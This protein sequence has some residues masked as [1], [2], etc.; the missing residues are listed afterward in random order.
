MQTK[1]FVNKP[2]PTTQISQPKSRKAEA[3]VKRC[4]AIWDKIAKARDFQDEKQ[5]ESL[6]RDC[7]KICGKFE[8][9]DSMRIST[10]IALASLLSGQGRIQESLPFLKNALAQ[11]KRHHRENHNFFSDTLL[12]ASNCFRNAGHYRQAEKVASTALE[13][14]TTNKKLKASVTDIHESL[15]L[16]RYT[17]GCELMGAHKYKQA[18]EVFESALKNVKPANFQRLWRE[19]MTRCC[20]A[21]SAAK[22]GNQAYAIEQFQT[23]LTLLSRQS[24]L[25]AQD[26]HFLLLSIEDLIHSAKTKTSSLKKLI[27]SN[28]KLLEK[29]RAKAKVVAPQRVKCSEKLHGKTISDPYQWMESIDSDEVLQWSWRENDAAEMFL[30]S[31]PNKAR[32]Q[33]AIQSSVIRHKPTVPYSVKK[34]YY[35]VADLQ[36]SSEKALWTCTANGKRKKIVLHPSDLLGKDEGGITNYVVSPNGRYVAFGVT[37]GGSEWQTWQIYDLVTKKKLKDSLT[38]LIHEFVLWMPGGMS[39]VYIR[40]TEPVHKSKRSELLRFPAIYYHNV[41]TNQTKDKLLYKRLDKPDWYIGPSISLGGRLALFTN[42]TEKANRSIVLAKRLMKTGD[43]KGR[44]MPIFPDGDAAYRYFTSRKGKLYFITDKDADK[45]RVIAVSAD[46][47][48]GKLGE[49][50]NVMAETKHLLESAYE[51]TDH[52]LLQYLE[53]GFSRI[54]KYDW[55]TLKSEGE[56]KL[57]FSG[58]V[59]DI[60]WV[61]D[62]NTYLVAAT[63]YLHPETI[64]KFSPNKDKPSI[65]FPSEKQNIGRGFTTTLVKYKSKDGTEIPMHLVHKKG[66]KLDRNNPVLLY[67]YG[68]FGRCLTP[69]YSYDVM[70]WLKL[71]GVYA[72]PLL[73]GG[74]ELGTKWHTDAILEGKNKTIEDIAAAA[75]WLQDNQWTNSKRIAVYGGSNGGLTAAATLVRYPKLFAAGVVINGLYD[76]LRYHRSTL[77]WTWLPEYGS[78]ENKEQFEYLRKY[79]PLHNLKNGE[80]YPPMFISVA[81]GDDRVLPW[82]SFKLAAALRHAQGNKGLVLLRVEEEAGHAWSRPSDRVKDQ[83]LFLMHVLKM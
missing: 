45:N 11:V 16:T 48:R 29:I 41:G 47:S 20:L 62:G 78:A 35:F 27:A 7:F 26:L 75:A 21:V 63:S 66:I 46:S 56:L 80:K 67:V 15:F 10:E 33:D 58:T 23:S 73:R 28:Q 53:N 9:S 1:S 13:I 52:L 49:P 69:E 19:G 54:R 5:Q 22:Q 76:M 57:P 51:G 6:L 70:A 81:R 82:H 38:G 40:H 71:G 65:F 8:P 43:A 64:Y 61:D 50:I 72:A 25:S 59:S 79:S 55:K 34:K 14:A 39:F 30:C 17:E 18:Q 42:W 37:K 12:H 83:L 68:G 74:G 32:I 44:L 60:R 77:A 36:D 3:E 4:H 24:K 31:L 2:S